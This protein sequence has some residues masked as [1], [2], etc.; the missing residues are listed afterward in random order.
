MYMKKIFISMFIFAFAV[1]ATPSSVAQAQ[2]P[3]WNGYDQGFAPENTTYGGYD[4][5]YT[6]N[7]QYTQQSACGISSFTANQYAVAPGSSV[8]VHWSTTGCDS[9]AITPAAIPANRPPSGS[10]SSE[11]IYST[12]TYTLT[13]Y[14]SYGVAQ[15][16]RSL[17]VTVSGQSNPTPTYPTPTYPGTQNCDITSFT[18]NRYTI[19]AGETITASWSTTGCDSV[20][21]TPAAIP[22]NRPPSGSVS[23]ERIYSTITYTLTAYD[24]YGVAQDSRSL[25]VTVRNGNN[26]NGSCSINSFYADDTSIDEGDETRLRWETTGCDDVDISGVG[27][28]LSSDG[29]VRI[30]PSRTRTYT[31]TA[32]PNGVTRQVTVSVDENNNTNNDQCS[33]DSFY[34]DNYS[35]S[36]GES[37]K[38][39]WRTT[40]AQDVDITP[41]LNNR[42]DDGDVSVRPTSTTTYTINVDGDGCFESQSFTIYVDQVN[43]TGSTVSNNSRPQAI[44]TIASGL[45]GGSVRLNG[46]AVP[47]TTTGTATAWFEW[48]QANSSL[49]NRTSAQTVSGTNTTNYTDVISGVVPGVTYAYRS[50]VQNRNGIAYGNTEVIPAA[51]IVASVSNTTPRP[52]TIVSTQVN[53]QSVT[54]RSNASLLELTVESE[55][56]R[57][58]VRGDIEYTVTY[59]NISPT[60]LTDAVL[61]VVLPKEL[62]YV[63]ATTGDYEVT[64]RTLTVDLKT[65]DVGDQGTVTVKARVNNEAVEGNLTVMTASVVYT[66]SVTRGQEDAIAYSLITI[67]EDCPSLLGASTAGF[68]SFLPDT[69]LEWLLLI[70]VILALILVGRALYKKKEQSAPAPIAK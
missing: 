28:N 32:Q 5:S 46:I 68:G 50:V 45:G 8:T 24:I 18:S 30:E 67:S 36:R 49:S 40:D 43:N 23:S 6:G 55:Y 1:V 62:T 10:V 25:T 33:I 48:G 39:Y 56:E 34:A 58:C 37:T 2:W 16:S 51:T 15:D 66:N 59:R 70:L 22:A 17:T 57:M 27:T 44:T 38:I 26:N 63:A 60:R 20:A 47:N 29:S 14:D 52:S 21:I 7:Q 42:R 64:S 41:G 3:S 69:L 9:V 53:R 31:L 13:A 35:I 65:L 19:D 54:A 11:R 61:Q 12:I 4:Y